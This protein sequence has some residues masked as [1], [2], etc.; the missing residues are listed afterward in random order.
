MTVG[1]AESRR[2]V[3]DVAHGRMR[4]DPRSEMAERLPSVV[5]PFLTWLTARPAP[6]EIMRERS[7]LSFVWGSIGWALLGPVLGAIGLFLCPQ[8]LA[9][10]V[11]GLSWLA[12]TYGLGLLQVVVFHHAS[13]GAVFVERRHNR[14]AGWLISAMLLFKHFDSYKTEHMLHHFSSKLLTHED[15]FADFVLGLCRLE[16]GVP[17]RELW[18]RV[19]W[20]VTF[21]PAFHL[22]FL[23]KRIRAALLSPDVA[24][25]AVGLGFWLAMALGALASGHF[26]M[27]VLLWVVPATVLLQLAT[28]GRILCEHRF[29]DERLIAARGR[30]FVCEATAG[31]FPGS[32]PPAANA[33]TGRGLGLWTL[34]WLDMLTIQL[35][36]RLFVLVGDAPCHDFHHRR[37]GAGQWTNYIHARQADVD[38]GCPGYSQNY[39]E[40]WG[41]FAA[42]DETL[43][44]LSNTRPDALSRQT[45]ARL[46]LQD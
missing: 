41:L 6:G 36:V 2:G 13:H 45:V 4:S 44:T 37:P 28:V 46:A 32:S 43:T 35:G 38:A 19:L 31:V 39:G 11:I 22:R 26:G 1:N 24:H 8:G 18:R 40:N 3:A 34:W 14:R 33:L 42:L 7:A 15:E 20:D 17:K 21:S 5:Q 16:P 27:W 23:A 12:T 10:V 25:D 9:P 29:P 30:D